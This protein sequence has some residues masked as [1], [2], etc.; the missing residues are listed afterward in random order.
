MPITHITYERDQQRVIDQDGLLQ[1]PD[2][3]PNEYPTL[4]RFAPPPVLEDIY[5]PRDPTAYKP[6]WLVRTSDM[7]PVRGSEVHERY[8]ALS[9]SWSQSGD[10]PMN[11][12]DEKQLHRQKIVLYRKKTKR[13]RPRGRTR[14]RVPMKPRYTSFEKLIQQISKDFGI[15]YI[16][17]DQWCINQASKEEKQREIKQ[18]H[19]IYKHAYCTVVL[20]PELEYTG[21]QSHLPGYNAVNIGAISKS[22]WITRAWTLEEAFMSKRLLFLGRNVHMWSH[23]SD[24]ILL[25]ETNTAMFLRAV[26]TRSMKWNACIALQYARKRTSTKEH[27]RYFALANMFHEKMSDLNTSYKQPLKDLALWFYE[28][29]AMDDISI[30]YFG[31]PEQF[32]MDNT[33]DVIV[34]GSEDTSLPS[35]TGIGGLHVRR[36]F[37]AG[38]HDTPEC[39]GI[40]AADYSVSGGSISITCTS[41]AVSIHNENMYDQSRELWARANSDILDWTISSASYNNLKFVVTTG[42]NMYDH[43]RI[44][45]AYGMRGTHF[46]PL[47]KKSSRT[48]VNDLSTPN[49]YG[50]VMSLTEYCSECII[51]FGVRYEDPHLKSCHVS[52]VIMRNGDYYKAIGICLLFNAPELFTNVVTRRKQNFIIK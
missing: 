3:S 22:E 35:W 52:P 23:T 37:T 36:L 6:T 7:K 34:E 15:R 30:L 14:I 8:Y 27:D 41:I 4:Y 18:M 38:K 29:L 13:R 45:D 17:W 48:L 16:W 51:L 28:R 20:V 9:Y 1:F 50:A 42:V 2:I 26:C 25:S 11:G 31:T 40:S 32:D 39:F 5:G 24:N 46:L 47:K 21:L 44:S 33:E 43:F 12:Q 10:C 49:I 19:N